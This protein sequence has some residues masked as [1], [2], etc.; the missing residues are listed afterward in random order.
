MKEGA[1]GW[2]CSLSRERPEEYRESEASVLSL[3]HTFC[4][5]ISNP[6]NQLVY[7]LIGIR[8]HLGCWPLLN[9]NQGQD[10]LERNPFSLRSI[11]AR[12]KSDDSFQHINRIGI[13]P[14]WA[15]GRRKVKSN[16]SPGILSFG[17]TCLGTR[18]TAING[19]PIMSASIINW[20]YCTGK[21]ITCL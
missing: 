7:L 15:R 19:I 2:A 18:T 12:A 13:W 3:I 16:S 10:K 9:E 20:I 8:G 21:A 5:W 17:R 11:E 4:F 6:I 1:T 14:C